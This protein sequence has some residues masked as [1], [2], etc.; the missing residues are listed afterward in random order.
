MLFAVIGRGE[1]K[2]QTI[3]LLRNAFFKD[4]GQD[5]APS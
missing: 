3:R 2:N 4:R 1:I 5:A